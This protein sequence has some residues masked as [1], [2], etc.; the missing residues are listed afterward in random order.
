MKYTSNDTMVR[1]IDEMIDKSCFN[2]KEIAFKLGMSAQ[3]FYNM[4][5][6]KKNISL[7]D[8]KKIADALGYTI[9]V[10]I[11][12]K[13]GNSIEALEIGESGKTDK[14]TLE[15]IASAQEMGIRNKGGKVEF[16]TQYKN[17]VDALQIME[18]YTRLLDAYMKLQGRDRHGVPLNEEKDGEATAP[19]DATAP[20]EAEQSEADGMESEEMK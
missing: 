4:T 20:K 10:T 8:I 7:N 13:Q 11:S 19:A 6:L 18:Y 16:Y 14:K 1:L 3:Q 15:A 17:N 2:R 12:D 5:K 9:D